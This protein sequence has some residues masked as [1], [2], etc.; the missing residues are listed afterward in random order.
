MRITYSTTAYIPVSDALLDNL[1]C[2][3][4]CWATGVGTLCIAMEDLKNGVDNG[5]PRNASERNMFT[6]LRK[7]I[8]K[9][10]EQKT[11]IGDVIFTN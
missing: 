7:A 2:S 8:K 5:R 3:F 1:L 10:E 11:P 9:I 4:N 6:Y